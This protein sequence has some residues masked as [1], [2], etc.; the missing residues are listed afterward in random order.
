MTIVVLRLYIGWQHVGSRLLSATVEYEETG[1]YDGQVWVKTP[2][3]LMR[4]RLL[5]NYSVKPAITR[6]KKTLLGLGTALALSVTMLALLPPPSSQAVFAD[7][8]MQTS[9]SSSSAVGQVYGQTEYEDNLR[10][11]E[12]WALEED[13]G[14]PEQMTSVL[15]HMQEMS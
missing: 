6:L 8:G 11:Y 2:Q 14:R 13:G 5:S 4:D 1:W 15:S 7:G 3:I 9:N 12:P 10:K